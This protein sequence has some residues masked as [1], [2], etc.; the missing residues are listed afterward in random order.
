MVKH[1]TA[2]FCSFYMNFIRHHL[3]LPSTFLALKYLHHLEF[4]CVTQN[5]DTF[6]SPTIS[7]TTTPNRIS[8]NQLCRRTTEDQ[9][10]SYS[11]APS[12]R[13]SGFDDCTNGWLRLVSIRS[14][15]LRKHQPPPP[16]PIPPLKRPLNLSEDA[17]LAPGTRNVRSAMKHTTTRIPLER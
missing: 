12:P 2:T 15:P 9:T 6:P 17:H 8:H 3:H 5:P 13:A 14:H 7:T 1:Q 10:H 16:P 11:S 4:L